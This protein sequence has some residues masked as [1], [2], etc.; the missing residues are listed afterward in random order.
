[1]F[2]TIIGLLGAAMVVGGYGLLATGRLK[3]DDMRYPLLNLV[4]TVFIL[5]SLY[6]Q[7][8]VPAIVTQLVWIVVSL[9]GML[10]I[11]RGAK[12]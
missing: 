2:G 12:R 10:R 4:G 7:P 9:L 8:N 3:S 6:F 5:V 1:M 11:H